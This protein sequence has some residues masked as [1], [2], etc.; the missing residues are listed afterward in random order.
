ML[1]RSIVQVMNMEILVDEM[2]DGL[3][4]KLNVMGYKAHSVKKL[5]KKGRH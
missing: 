1:L 2:Y 3:D 5:R 4:E